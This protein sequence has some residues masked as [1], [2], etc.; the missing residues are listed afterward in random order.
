MQAD[1]HVQ[2]ARDLLVKSDLHFAYGDRIQGS[3]MLWGAAAHSMLALSRLRR[4]P[5]GSHPRLGENAARISMELGEPE[6]STDFN[7]AERFHANFYHDFMTA[8]DIGVER[9]LIHRFVNRVLSLPELN[10]PAP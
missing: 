2:T 9:P 1:E 6:L 8:S 3:E 5:L 7:S 10:S 4:W